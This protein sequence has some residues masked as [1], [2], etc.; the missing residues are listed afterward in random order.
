[1]KPGPIGALFSFLGAFML[2]SKLTA[3]LFL[4]VCLSGDKTVMTGRPVVAPVALR[5]LEWEIRLIRRINQDI[6]AFG[7]FLSF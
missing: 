1:M 3:Y 5:L 6:V 4:S 2:A 7:R